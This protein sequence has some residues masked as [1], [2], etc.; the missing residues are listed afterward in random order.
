MRSFALAILLISASSANAAY[1]VRCNG[2]DVA[3]ASINSVL[4]EPRPGGSGSMTR[5]HGGVDIAQCPEGA[6]VQAIYAGTVT[7]T[8]VT[9]CTSGTCV[10]VTDSATHAFEYE[11]L[12]SISVSPGFIAAGTTLGVV[13][14]S[15]VL[16]LQET[17][18]IAGRSTRVNPLRVGA[19]N[20]NR[21]SLS[22][23]FSTPNSA[24]TTA[25][26]LVIAPEYT[27]GTDGSQASVDAFAYRDGTYF[28]KGL[29][30][31]ALYDGGRFQPRHAVVDSEPGSIRHRSHASPLTRH[32]FHGGGCPRPPR[33]ERSDRGIDGVGWKLARHRDAP[34]GRRDY[35]LVA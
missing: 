1:S 18:V 20:F 4:G 19:L 17:V 21:G 9:S 33:P 27:L 25:N 32:R 24:Y 29:E 31:P 14:S 22:A 35:P 13:T 23:S 7:L 11:H 12:D 8:G 2:A 6:T 30:D 15:E 26:S 10:R 28:I 34:P 5:F 16:H 3:S